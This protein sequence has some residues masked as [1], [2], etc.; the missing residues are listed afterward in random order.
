MHK[1]I[2]L[3]R[4]AFFSTAACVLGL[5]LVMPRTVFGLDAPAANTPE[6][7]WE[8]AKKR[9]A[10]EGSPIETGSLSDD[11]LRK[12]VDTPTPQSLLTIPAV[13]DYFWHN[14]VY[15]ERIQAVLVADHT[16]SSTVGTFNS[17]WVQMDYCK[18]SN[19][20]YKRTI[21]DGGKTQAVSYVFTITDPTSLN[22]V[23]QCYCE[24]YYTGT[25]RV[26]SWSYV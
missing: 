2:S 18:V 24:F 13:S 3:T 23:I 26:A 19:L 14:L 17:T 1:D 15:R 10:E 4:R 21:L 25:G 22:A 7:Y 20:T 9:A 8:I 11:E 6:E 12:L 16:S 5:G